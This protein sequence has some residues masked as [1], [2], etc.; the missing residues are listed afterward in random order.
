MES[1]EKNFVIAHIAPPQ[2]PVTGD[3][4]YRVLQPDRALGRVDGLSVVSL[5]NLSPHKTRI[6]READL[7]IIQMLGDLDLLPIFFKRKKEGKTTVFE[8]SDNFFDFQPTNPARG[9]YEN[10]ENQLL[11][12]QLLA[13][14]DAVQFTTPELARRFT[15]FNDTAATFPNQIE[16]VPPL[17]ER[18]HSPL[19]VGWGGSLAH[20]DDMRAVAPTL[21]EWLKRN[22]GVHLAIM[23]PKQI[24]D[25]FAGVPPDRK[26]H[27]EPGALETYF[28]F[29]ET[30][31]VGIAPLKDDPFNL[32]RSDVKFIEYASRGVVPVCSR[33]P[34]YTGS[35]KNSGNG[36]LF[37][38]AH[39][40][41]ETLEKLRKNTELLATISQ[42]AHRYVSRER[43]EQLHAK[44]RADFYQ[45]FLAEPSSESKR[46]WEWITSQN[47]ATL[48]AGSRHCFL[49]LSHTEKLLY[50]G[51]EQQFR[52]GSPHNAVRYFRAAA[53]A[54][55]DFYI[56][57]LYSAN[58]HRAFDHAQAL[59]DCSKAIE[60]EP[61]SPAAALALAEITNISIGNEHSAIQYCKEC[62][63]MFPCFTT[64]WIRLANMQKSAGHTDAAEKTLKQALD[65]EPLN[66]VAAA[67]LTSYLIDSEKHD[68]AEAL[69]KK[70]AER[71][72]AIPTAVTRLAN[73]SISSG[74][75][76]LA[77]S[78]L[79][80]KLN[81]SPQGQRYLWE[82]V[83]ACNKINEQ[84]RT[85]TAIR[86][87]KKASL[88]FPE[89]PELL[90]RIG[91]L[92]KKTGDT[93]AARDSWKKLLSIPNAEQYHRLIKTEL[94]KME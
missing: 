51:M 19:V 89:N 36:F 33:I 52:A 48:S 86:Y 67:S 25:L 79:L 41:V 77:A 13:R 88:L 87:L 42:N 37:Q 69:M 66:F 16:Y 22:S 27:I 5:M 6:L 75:P 73:A 90:Y 68:E 24:F 74:K 39:E 81:E 32:C 65:A 46:L 45:R 23:G 31:H 38:N 47:E 62:T 59:A 64:A 21:T 80:E 20:I 70:F 71:Y 30:L 92:Y 17:P 10:P 49:E 63:D 93:T 18:P 55:P 44:K 15:P 28:K 57:F 40:L 43:T 94:A 72:T 85:E 83:K 2:P 12:L 34:T 78:M 26:K 50:A 82:L 8:V 7:L 53:E 91:R 1:T 84:N 76:E 9:F 35:I 29:L 4:V 3:F 11:L 60:I 58:S 14:A 54:A 61:G 56:P